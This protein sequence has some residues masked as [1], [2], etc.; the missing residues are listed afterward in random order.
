MYYKSATTVHRVHT[1]E[2]SSHEAGPYDRVPS[3][4]LMGT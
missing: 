2:A 1:L 4:G 3:Y